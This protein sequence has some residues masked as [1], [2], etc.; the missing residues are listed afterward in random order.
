[1]WSSPESGKLE[2]QKLTF[3]RLLKIPSAAL[4]SAVSAEMT[5]TGHPDVLLENILPTG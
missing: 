1:M 5:Q 3:A 2:K 4:S